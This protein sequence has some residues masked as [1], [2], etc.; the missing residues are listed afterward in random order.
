MDLIVARLYMLGLPNSKLALPVSSA[1]R[2]D[3]SS[4]FQFGLSSFKI[5]FVISPT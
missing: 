5:D 4:W 3:R 2:E 1:L